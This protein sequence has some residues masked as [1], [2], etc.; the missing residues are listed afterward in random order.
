MAAVPD[1][2]AYAY[3][4]P[5]IDAKRVSSAATKVPFVL[6]S[7]PLRSAAVTAAISSSPSVL[8]DASWSDGSVLSGARGRVVT[9]GASCSVR[10]KVT[11]LAQLAPQKRGDLPRKEGQTRVLDH[12][13]RRRSDGERCSANAKNQQEGDDDR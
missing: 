8:P 6:V 12:D 4:M 10:L 9:I 13:R 7:V 1:E 11:F 2:H 5:I 3:F